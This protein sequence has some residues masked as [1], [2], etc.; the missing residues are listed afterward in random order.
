MEDTKELSFECLEMQEK[1][2][3]TDR[4]RSVDGVICLCLFIMV[5]LRVRLLK[6]QR[7]LDFC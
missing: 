6:Y 4:A 7:W 2:I 3:P 5:T 1:N